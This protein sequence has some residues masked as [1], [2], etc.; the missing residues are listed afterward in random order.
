[1]RGFRVRGAEKPAAPLPLC[2]TV[3]QTS[4]DQGN[5]NIEK[6]TERNRGGTPTAMLQASP[7]HDVVF[8]GDF[9]ITS[10]RDTPMVA[11]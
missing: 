7:G 3:R 1:M 9:P 11:Q 10:Y 2:P 6:N 4:H 8:A 5:L